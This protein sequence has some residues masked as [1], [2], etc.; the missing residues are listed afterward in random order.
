MSQ[1]HRETI[2]PIKNG[3][4]GIMFEFQLRSENRSQQP[5][6]KGLLFCNSVTDILV[7]KI[8]VLNDG[9][10][11]GLRN[12]SWTESGWTIED[13]EVRHDQPTSACW[14]LCHTLIRRP[15]S[16][17]AYEG[18]GL[19]LDSVTQILLDEEVHHVA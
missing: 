13:T 16:S 7:Q 2:R 12:M 6:E 1:W 15:D 11:H 14:T 19:D 3:K 18:G 8:I 9:T 17:V 4:G 5:D 10:E